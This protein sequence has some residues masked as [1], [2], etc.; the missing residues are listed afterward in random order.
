MPD[1]TV[2]IPGNAGLKDQTMALHWV[3]ENIHLFG[4]DN[5]NITL[6]GESAGGA[7]VHWH[8]LS[9][10]SKGLFDK[11][12]IQSGSALAHWSNIPQLNWA[13]RLAKR[14][15]WNEEG[16]S[17]GCYKF[18]K[19]VDAVEIVKVQEKI[20]SNEEKQM[21]IFSPWA[22]TIEPYVSK[23][24]FSTKH[25]SELYKSAW[26]N[27]IPL[28][29]GGNS[30]EG[31]LWYHD[32]VSNSS[33]YDQ[34]DSFENLFSFKFGVGSERTKLYAAKTKQFYYGEEQPTAQNISKFMDILADRN[35]LHGINLAVKGRIDDPQSADT[36]LYRFNFESD[37]DFTMIKRVIAT[38]DIRG[39]L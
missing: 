39:N 27:K 22:P 3:R 30:E 19:N 4:G 1:P 29:I 34:E 18:L 10:F 28:I 7:S 11:A 33:R 35:F 23:Q 17:V 6:F 25:P 21:W 37:T 16:G 31:L 8:M 13:K 20:M 9:E 32:L 14:M 12:I 2:N 5:K 36:Y 24:T 38:N 26:G 15:G